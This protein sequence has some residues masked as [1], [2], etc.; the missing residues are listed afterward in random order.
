M[1]SGMFCAWTNQAATQF[2]S[3]DGGNCM[4]PQ[5][6]MGIT[7]LS[8]SSQAPATGKLTDDITMAGPVVVAAS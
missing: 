7:Y 2:T 5:N 6:L 1:G 3:F 8:L 4:V